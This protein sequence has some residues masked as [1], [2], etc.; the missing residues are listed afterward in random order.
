MP[1]GSDPGAARACRQLLRAAPP[2]ILAERRTPSQAENPAELCKAIEASAERIRLLTWQPEPVRRW[3]PSPSVAT[4]RWSASTAAITARIAAEILACLATRPR[5]LLPGISELTMTN[6]ANAMSTS[7]NA[8]RHAASTS[9]MLTDAVA[10]HSPP[11]LRDDLTDL[12][13]RMGRLAYA[14]PLWAPT[15]RRR[16]A[17]KAPDQLTPGPAELRTVLAA[18]HHAADALARVASMNQAALSTSSDAGLILATSCPDAIPAPVSGLASI[19]QITR[20]AARCAAG[21]LDVQAQTAS[22]PSAFWR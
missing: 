8:W 21:A 18:V 11:P 3:L 10:W 9:A 20:D 13:I 7:W 14:N 1:P 16:A 17:L 6:A 19:Y 5:P 22:T 12:M 2:G 4:L 15:A